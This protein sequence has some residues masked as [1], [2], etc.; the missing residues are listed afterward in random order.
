MKAKLEKRGGAG[1][2]Q[3]RKPLDPDSETVTVAVRMTIA[4]RAKLLRIGGSAWIRARIDKARDV[5]KEGE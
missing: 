3:G 5:L 1:R 4:Q 2:G